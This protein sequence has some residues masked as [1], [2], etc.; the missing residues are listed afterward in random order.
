METPASESGE[1]F[2][3]PEELAFIESVKEYTALSILKA[4]KLE[5][6]DKYRVNDLA[7]EYAQMR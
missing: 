7:Q 5:S 2:A 1:S 3:S 6:F 4:L